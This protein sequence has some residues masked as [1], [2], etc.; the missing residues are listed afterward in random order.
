MLNKKKT[1]HEKQIAVKCWM[2]CNSF[3]H[4]LNVLGLDKIEY[5]QQHEN[6]DIYKKAYEI[7]ESHFRDD[8]DQNVDDNALLP[9]ST[10]SHYTFGDVA[11]PANG[12]A[13]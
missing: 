5:L 11:A 8:E 9:D 10:S 7:I 1:D 4:I 12:F 13:L 2:S 3:I 6:E